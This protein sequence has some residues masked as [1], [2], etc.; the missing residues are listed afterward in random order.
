[1]ASPIE[2][3]FVKERLVGKSVFEFGCAPGKLAEEISSMGFKVT[4]IDLYDPEIVSSY[5]FIKG[6]LVELFPIDV[7]IDKYENVI[8]VSS[9]EHSGIESENFKIEDRRSVGYHVDVAKCLE[10]MLTPNGQLIVTVPFGD[11]ETYY[12]DKNGN[13]GTNEEIPEPAWGFRTYDKDSLSRLFSGLSLDTCKAYKKLDDLPY[14]SIDS[15]EE[16]SLD[17]YKDFNNK[18]RAVMCCVFKKELV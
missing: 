4:A 15:W 12:V 11:G 3:K 16:I 17:S 13:N 5:T 1:M 6:D 14:F 9:I 8:A 2:E 18:K 7:T 10:E